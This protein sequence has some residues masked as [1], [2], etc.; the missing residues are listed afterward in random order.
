MPKLQSGDPLD[1]THN[2]FDLGFE[3]SEE[4]SEELDH[5]NTELLPE[6]PFLK[7]QDLKTQIHGNEAKSFGGRM[8]SP[9]LFAQQALFPQV[10]QLRCW[11]I[12]NGIPT[13]IGVI[14]ANASEEDFVQRFRG[15]MPKNREGTFRFKMRPLDMTGR[16][17]GQ[18]ITLAISEHHSALGN[19]AT[20]ITPLHN[21]L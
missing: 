14:D 9:K 21:K 11:R 6:S 19:S 2:D 17:L 7:Q 3:D 15:A 20:G 16:E 1:P 4:D 13:G 10:A 8:S 5:R 18:E 12:E